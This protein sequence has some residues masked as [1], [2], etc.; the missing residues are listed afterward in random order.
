M[1]PEFP[2][3]SDVF[4]LVVFL[5]VVAVVSLFRRKSKTWSDADYLAARDRVAR[6]RRITEED[7]QLAGAIRRRQREGVPV[8]KAELSFAWEVEEIAHVV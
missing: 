8:S 1:M 5:L 2:G 3:L 4:W 6:S 7:S